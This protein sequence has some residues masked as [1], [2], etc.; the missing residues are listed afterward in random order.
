MVRFQLQRSQDLVRA[1]NKIVSADTTVLRA[2]FYYKNILSGEI[3]SYWRRDDTNEVYKAVLSST[4]ECDVPWEALVHRETNR[5]YGGLDHI[6]WVSLADEQIVTTSECAFK[7]YRSVYSTAA[8]ESG[9]VPSP[10]GGGGAVKSVNGY[11]GDVVL[12]A[13]DVGV[14]VSTDEPD[15]AVDGD[16]WIEPDNDDQTAKVINIDY[17]LWDDGLLTLTLSDGT[18]SNYQ[19]N[20]DDSGNPITITDPDGIPTSISW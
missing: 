20:F 12:T 8:S 1:D 4:G 7:I 2:S 14:Y 15:A 3:T 11:T 9:D 19:I 10:G 16:I 13:D 18:I 17:S 6:V 5:D